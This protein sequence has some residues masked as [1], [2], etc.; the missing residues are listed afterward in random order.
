MI[1]HPC[2]VRFHVGNDRRQPQ[3]AVADL[4]HTA[5][6]C[7][8]EPLEIEGAVPAPLGKG[9]GVAGIEHVD[10]LIVGEEG[11]ARVKP[12]RRRECP[13]AGRRSVVGQMRGISLSPVDHVMPARVAAA[14]GHDEQFLQLREG[15]RFEPGF[16]LE[17]PVGN[18]SAY[19]EPAR[20]AAQQRVNKADGHHVSETVGQITCL[21]GNL[22]DGMVKTQQTEETKRRPH[23][24]ADAA[25]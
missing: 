8:Q 24:F 14:G 20:T 4:F 3:P 1:D 19:E 7:Q 23:P 15:L 13:S 17:H 12:C 10:P 25:L 9:R 18:F 5:S 2:V 21:H 22:S 6:C 11:H 16:V